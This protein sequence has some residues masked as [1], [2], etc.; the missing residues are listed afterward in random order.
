MDFGNGH[1]PLR[2]MDDPQLKEAKND[3]GFEYYLK[4][5]KSYGLFPTQKILEVRKSK[6]NIR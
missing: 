4:A 2:T 1:D 5:Q 6:K 3:E